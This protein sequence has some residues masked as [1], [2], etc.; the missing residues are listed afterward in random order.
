L[1]YGEAVGEVAVG[2]GGV[3]EGLGLL[4]ERLDGIGSGGEPQG[5]PVEGAGESSGVISSKTLRRSWRRC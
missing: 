4:L 1:I 3:E 5:W 2:V